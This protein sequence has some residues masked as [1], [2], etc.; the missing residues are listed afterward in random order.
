MTCYI[1]VDLGFFLIIGLLHTLGKGKANV[2]AL[3]GIRTRVPVYELLRPRG[4]R[5]GTNPWLQLTEWEQR[6]P[7]RQPCVAERPST[8][9][10]T[11]GSALKS[12]ALYSSVT[13]LPAPG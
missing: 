9:V 1:R 12:V 6:Q 7:V 5:F 10:S 11:F 13:K 2:H 4:Q 8:G 3:S